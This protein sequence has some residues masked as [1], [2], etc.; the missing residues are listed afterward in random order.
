MNKRLTS[1]P[2]F[3]IRPP[4]TAGEIDT[5]FRLNAQTFRPDEDTALVAARRRRLIM[6]DPDFQ[7]LQLHSA[8]YGQTYVGSYRI[9]ER[10][11]CVETARFLIGCIGGVVT[12]PDYQ[13][14]GVATAMMQDA[15]ATA[16]ARRCAFLLLHGVP[17]YY[18]QRGYIDVCED[19]PRHAIARARI[20]VDA[21][22]ECSVRNAELSDAPTLLALYQQHYGTEASLCSFAPTRTVERQAHYLENWFQE[23]IPLLAVNAQGVAEGYLL[24]SRRRGQLYVY[25]AAANSWPAVLALLQRHH[26]LLEIEADA[27]SE[28]YWPLPLTEITL[29]LLSDHLPVR[30]E[31]QS[32]PDDDWM[33]R[34]A[35][36]SALLPAL[37]RLWQTRW[38]RFDWAGRIT[39]KVDEQMYTVE[40]SPEGVRLVDPVSEEGQRVVLSQQVFTQLVF[41]FR[42]VAWAA[43]QAGQQIPEELLPILGALFPLR[44]SGFAGSDYF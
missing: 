14:Q 21:T 7:R 36:F 40:L 30:S 26:R 31:M 34:V 44:Q 33:A 15:L 28:L 8:F 32:S 37:L 10:E 18:K 25:E 22:P 13:H 4:E 39:F 42:S 3:V 24:L 43:G 12:H 9:Q 2:D 11:L 20:P 41:G 29:H 16:R 17:G 23:N 6:R 1:S 19:M 27:A 38:R 5:Y 35:S